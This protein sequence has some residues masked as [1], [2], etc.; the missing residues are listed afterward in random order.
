MAHLKVNGCFFYRSTVNGKLYRI[1]A[2][3]R[4]DLP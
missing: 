2:Y 1:E 3:T 4:R